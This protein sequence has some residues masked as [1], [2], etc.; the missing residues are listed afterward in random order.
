MS[1]KKIFMKPSKKQLSNIKHL[2]GLALQD[3]YKK[4]KALF[5]RYPKEYKL[6]K[7]LAK[8]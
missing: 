8:I 7:K 6:A 4:Q 3:S 2:I 1:N 5:E